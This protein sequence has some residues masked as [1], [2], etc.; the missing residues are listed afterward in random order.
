MIDASLATDT[1]G[2]RGIRLLSMRMMAKFSARALHRFWYAVAVLALS[3]PC[4]SQELVLAV[5]TTALSLPLLVAYNQGYF[6]AEGVSVRMQDCIGGNRC[7][8][9]LLD[10][11]AQLATATD[12]PV[13]FNSF[14]RSDFAI[15]ATF[16][17]SVN[18]LKLITRKSAGI[19]SARHLEGK[20]V[21]TVKGTSAHYFLDSYLIFNDVD[22]KRVTVVAR[23]PE[24]I[25]AALERKEVDAV[26]IWE[27]FAYLALKALGADGAILSSPRIYTETFNLVADRRTMATREYDL[28]RVLR[29]L[30]Q[31][32]QFIRERPKEAQ[33]I[34]LERLKLDQGFVDWAWKDLDFRTS[35]NQS[36]L[37]T[38]EAEARWALR[39]GHVAAGKRIPNLLD[40]VHSAPLRKAVPGAVTL[41]Q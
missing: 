31:A 19:T 28:V 7:L 41:V 15:L 27:P 14:E 13:M 35:L 16:V 25:A 40:F 36:L 4:H 1:S 37:S 10:G 17:S 29:A 2:Q 32:Q 8:K 12:I 6:T 23:P 38:L 24:E 11:K 20:R 3:V 21:A 33:A 39:E 5:S 18:D 26:A 9:L 22:T 30:E 34:L